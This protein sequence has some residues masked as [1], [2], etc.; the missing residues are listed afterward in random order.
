MSIPAK[1]KKINPLL[2]LV[3]KEVLEDSRRGIGNEK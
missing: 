2:Q 3:L 1:E